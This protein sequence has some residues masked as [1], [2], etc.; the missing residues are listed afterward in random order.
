MIVVCNNTKVSKLVYDWIAG[1]EKKDTDGENV[2]V[3]GNLPI[4]N[5]ED[6]GVWSDQ[7]NTLLIDSNQLESGE[8][9]KGEFKKA[10]HT[11]IEHFKREMNTDKVTDADLLREAMNT[12]G[13]KGKLGEQ[14]KCVVSVSMLSEGWDAKRVTHILGV[15]AFSTQLLCEQVVGRGLRRSSHDVEKTTIA[16]NGEDIALE[17]FP[18][19]YAEV[20]G[21][22]FSFIPATG[23]GKTIS[24]LPVTEV[25]ALPERKA[26][27]EITF[28]IVAGYRRQLSPNRLDAIFTEE[29]RYV[30]TTA[31][32]PVKIE[33]EAITGGTREVDLPYVERFREQETEYYLAR[34]VMNNYLLDDDDEAKWW[35][36][37]QVL[38][39][40]RQWMKEC[41]SYKDN[42]YPQYFQIGE[43]GRKAAFRIYQAILKAEQRNQGGNPTEDNA[44]KIFLPFFRDK[45]R[46][47][48]TQDVE[49]ETT[50]PT[51]ETRPD[52]CHISHV[53]ADT[54]SW[55]QK[56]AQALEQMDEVVAYVKN[57]NLGFTIPYVNHNGAHRQ[58]VPDFIARIR[59]Q[60]EDSGDNIVNL[61]LETSGMGREDKVQKVN[62]MNNM[63]VPAVNN[64]GEFGEWTFLEITD[65]WDMQNTIR[66]FMSEYA[67]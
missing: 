31:E 60:G 9:L 54:E 3:K 25:E 36:F 29:A 11:Q 7:L 30:L 35:L 43:I 59:K 5:N 58:Y 50:Q 26:K 14:I 4:F 2:V 12:V 57:H 39:I 6:N 21:V 63:W 44:P 18:P 22:P 34:I 28:P 32:I 66:E 13:K 24:P 47:G 27:C 8:A 19:E 52:K 40:T 15:R 46:T 48:S 38:R 41:V 1:W 49:F 20:Y 55:E 37:P 10:A 53:V 62:T 16:I 67:S 33:I 23:S 56:T 65:P 42:M 51:W 64:S 17:T 61:I 45:E